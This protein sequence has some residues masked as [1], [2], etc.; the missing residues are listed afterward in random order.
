MLVYQSKH[1][2]AYIGRLV[3]LVLAK[4]FAI[5]VSKVNYTRRIEPK[6]VVYQIY[7]L[8]SVILL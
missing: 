1:W 6:R 4:I 7:L 2:F 3:P 5:C 8:K